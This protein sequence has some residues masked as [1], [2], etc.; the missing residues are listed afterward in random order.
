MKHYTLPLC[1]CLLAAFAVVG[2]K[3]ETASTETPATQID[4]ISRQAR[5]EVQ[6]TKE[7]LKDKRDDFRVASDRRLAEMDL[8]LDE[9]ERKA[10]SLKDDAK[11]EADRTVKALREQRNKLKESYGDLKDETRSGWNDLKSAFDRSLDEL[12]KGLK[13]AKAKFD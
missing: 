7:Y 13:D 9:Y 8:K 4:Q 6:D 1:G 2:C 3:K 12:E 5:R 11:V 10:A